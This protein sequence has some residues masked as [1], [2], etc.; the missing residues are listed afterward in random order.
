MTNQIQQQF[1]KAVVVTLV[2]ILANSCKKTSEEEIIIERSTV[3]DQEGIVYTT[4][5]IGNQWWMA[6]NLKSTKFNDGSELVYI[7]STNGQDTAWQNNT[8]PAYTIV[9]NGQNG[10]LYHEAVLHGEK[11]IAPTGWHIAT[12]ED[13]KRLEQTIGMS[14]DETEQT[15]WRGSEE[16]DLITSKYNLGWPA[17]DQDNQLYGLDK[18]GFNALPTGCRGTDGRTNIQ[19]NTAFWWATSEDSSEVFYRYID[20]QTKKIFRQQIQPGYGMSIRCVKD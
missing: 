9:G 11:I 18:Y 13:W 16:A 8:L 17:N 15:G 4:V 2:V 5:K 12:D 7:E 1:V 6:E 14:T 19:N 20:S 10:L 3:T